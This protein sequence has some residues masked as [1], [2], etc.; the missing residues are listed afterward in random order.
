VAPGDVVL[1]DKGFP[2]IVE[3][4]QELGAFVCMPSFKGGE[5][6]FSN[7]ENEEGYKIVSVGIHVERA[8][9]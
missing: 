3:S 6:Q 5:K 7:F 8:I 1:E 9:S 4:T 2:T